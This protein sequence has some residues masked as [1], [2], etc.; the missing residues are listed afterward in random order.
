MRPTLESLLTRS[1]L[2]RSA[3]AW[4]CWPM[5]QLYRVLS[6]AHRSWYAM[7]LGRV[8]RAPVP[9]VVV[10]NV[11]AG[12]VGKTPVVMAVVEHFTQQ[13]L[14]VGIVSRGHGGTH[15]QARLVT[16]QDHASDVGDEP[17]LLSRRCA[18]PV[19][20]G[21]RRMDAV[22]AL[23]HAYPQTQLLVSDDGLQ[24]HAMWHDVALCV[25]DER[26]VGNGWPLPSGPLREAWPRTPWPG[27]VQLVV[28]TGVNTASVSQPDDKTSFLAERRLSDT[29]R[30]GRGQTRAL[31]DWI[32]QDVHAL[33]GI[34][35]PDRFFAML[36]RQGLQLRTRHALI[37]HATLQELER[38]LQGTPGDRDWLC[39]EKDAVKLWAHHPD[40]WAVPLITTLP[41]SLLTRLDAL[42]WPK[43]S[44]PHGHQIA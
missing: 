39:T 29:A 10:G 18:V 15:S 27:S 30:N 16:P 36:E 37:D 5:A 11:V 42:V 34:A 24:H 33:A 6:W 23:M 19:A 4:L 12:G 26:G 43:L 35:H 13:G 41:A 2:Q 14:Q 38:P 9:L 21:R 3:W 7:G 20:V 31:S 28:Q 25:F 22:R 8:E 40:V 17:L 1:W 32:G 44:L